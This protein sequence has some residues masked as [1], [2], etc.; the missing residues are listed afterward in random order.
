MKGNK[1]MMII[2]TDGL[3]N[4]FNNGYHISTGTYLKSCKKSLLKTINI[5]S[6]IMCIVVQ[7]DHSFKYNPVRQLFKPSKIMN[8]GTMS[9]AS[10]RVIKRFKQMIMRSLV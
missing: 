6:N 2:I 8:V 7:D 1:K 4:H 10:E 5:T 9:K 3:P